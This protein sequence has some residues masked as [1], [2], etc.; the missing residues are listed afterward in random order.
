MGSCLANKIYYS[1]N[2]IVY[3]QKQKKKSNCMFFSTLWGALSKQIRE[4]SQPTTLCNGAITRRECDAALVGRHL[5]PPSLGSIENVVGTTKIRSDLSSFHDGPRGAN[6]ECSLHGRSNSLERYNDLQSCV[7]NLFRFFL[8][9]HRHMA[10][11]LTAIPVRTCVEEGPLRPGGQGQSPTLS[12]PLRVGAS[13]GQQ[14]FC[15]GRRTEEKE[16]GSGS[17]KQ[18]RARHA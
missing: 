12:P 1:I 8:L 6:F 7:Y 17:T 5:T 2:Y 10:R 14:Q 16:I 15:W 13:L 11:Y 9:D 3:S 18:S 4:Q